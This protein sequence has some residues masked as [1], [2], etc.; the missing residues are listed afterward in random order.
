MDQVGAILAALDPE[1]EGRSDALAEALISRLGEEYGDV[2]I[3]DA[4]T[5]D[6]VLS[7]ANMTD[8][9]FEEMMNNDAIPEELKAKIREARNRKLE[10]AGVQTAD[11][12]KADEDYARF[13]R[14]MNNSAIPNKIKRQFREQFPELAALYDERRG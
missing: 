11:Q 5:R 10:E 2:G 7:A 12:S 6:R 13:E 3:Q 4:L 8:Q 1:L 14:M 9:Q